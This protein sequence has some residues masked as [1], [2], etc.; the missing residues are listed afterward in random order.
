MKTVNKKDIFGLVGRKLLHS[1]SPLMHN[2][3]FQREN[4]YA[5]YFLFEVEPHRLKEAAGGILALGLRGVNVTFPYKEKVGDFLY[6]IDPLAEKIGAVNTIKVKQGHLIGY[7]TDGEG[8]I[9]SLKE[10]ASFNPAGKKCLIVGAGGAAKSISMY[11]LKEKIDFLGIYDINYKKSQ[12][13]RRRLKNFFSHTQVENLKT[14]NKKNLPSLDLIINATPLGLHPSDP[15]AI[16]AALIKRGVL[17]YDL[18]Y[19]PLETKLLKVARRKGA[20]T[21]SGLWMLIY[22]GLRS[23]EIWLDRNLEGKETVLYRAILKYVRS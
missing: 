1:F 11:L 4:I 12:K 2:Y 23:L 10:K 19:N 16:P 8:F 20:R 22:Q 7:N 13:L 21:M 6:R 17:V 14:V 18:V 3:F 9:K 5:E 15:L